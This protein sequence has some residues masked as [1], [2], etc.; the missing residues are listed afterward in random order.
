MHPHLSR[1]L[2]TKK[3][4][5]PTPIQAAAIPFAIQGRDVVGVAQTVSL[6]CNSFFVY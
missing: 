3:F 1:A 2:H 4:L 6:S 5:E